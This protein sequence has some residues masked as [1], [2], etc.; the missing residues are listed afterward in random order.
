M[1]LINILIAVSL[2]ALGGCV[3]DPAAMRRGGDLYPSF[4][5][6]KAANVEGRDYSSE[7]YL[8]GSP[9]TVFAVHG[10]D[11][12]LGTARLARL[13]AGRDLNLYLFN[14]W[15][16]ADSGRLHVTATHFDDPAA[17]QLATA[18]VLGIALHAQADRG[19]YVCVGGK[20]DVVARLVVMRLEAAGFAA[21]TPCARLPGTSAKNIVNL[22]SAGGVQL[23]IT[24]RLLRKLEDEPE[25]AARFT[26]ALRLAAFEGMSEINRRQSEAAQPGK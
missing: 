15:L 9:I 26:E 18:S 17:V 21:A 12:E 20:N 14:G 24:L 6:L 3:S 5:A 19:S 7:V 11:I 25:E 16:G 4:S 8:R 13:T 22:P 23:E 10:G 1:K 2:A